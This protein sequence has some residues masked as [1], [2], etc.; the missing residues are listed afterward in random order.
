MDLDYPSEL[1]DSHNDYP[2]A[3][4]R[5]NI[6]PDILSPTAINIL[7]SMNTKSP[8]NNEKLV[9]NLMSK[10][11]YVVHYRALQLY[12]SLGLKLKRIHRVL[13]FTQ[14]PWLGKY[15]DFNTKERAKATTPFQKDFFKLMNNAVFGKTME[16]LRNRQDI[17]LVNNVKKAEKLVASP[18]F[19]SFTKIDDELVAIHRKLT[20]L[21]LSRPVQCGAAI[22]DISKV[23]MYNFHYNVILKKYGS[24]A[25]LL[26]TDTDS[27]TY[28]ITTPNLEQDLRE[29]GQY[30]DFSDYPPNHPLYNTSNKKKIG[31]FKDELNGKNGLEFVGLRPKMYSLLSE[32]GTKQ[33]AKGIN[34]SVAK[35]QLKHHMFKTCLE[36]LEPT[37]VQQNRIGS[38]RHRIYT[39]QQTKRALSAFD[40]KR[41]LLND[42]VSSYAYGHY[43]IAVSI[44]SLEFSCVV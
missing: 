7:T 35:Q 16:N 10:S 37:T 25:K 42:A 15:I 28:E 41:Y 36:T 29:L 26:F 12:L 14:S 19:T 11:N 40:D 32:S 8:K 38:E 33:A 31:Y 22:L 6:T 5:F 27:L 44:I 1:H 43:R 34:R 18:S 9:P 30:F 4:E 24:N 2:L 3:P 20:T 23:L 21:T 13:K 17:R 39:L